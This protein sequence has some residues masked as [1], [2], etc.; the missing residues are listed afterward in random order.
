MHRRVY[1]ECDG[2][3]QE[4]KNATKKTATQRQP[5]FY[6]SGTLVNLTYKTWPT[7]PETNTNIKYQYS[8][9]ATHATQ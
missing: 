6:P 4:P 9:P 8:P 7:I 3:T 5:S 2:A 1:P